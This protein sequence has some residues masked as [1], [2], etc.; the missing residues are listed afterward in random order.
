MKPAADLDP[1]F[2]P[3]LPKYLA[4]RESECATL[5]LALQQHDFEQIT[6]IGHRL[7]GSGSSY[8]FPAISA[9]GRALEVAG[10]ARDGD[11]AG[12]VIGELEALVRAALAHL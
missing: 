4:A 9:H 2:R 10:R 1:L 6:D 5:H 8:G 11:T 7:A 3:L 12:A